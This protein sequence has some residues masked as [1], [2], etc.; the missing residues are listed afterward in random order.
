[1]FC[2]WGFRSHIEGILG[3]LLNSPAQECPRRRGK[4]ARA[5]YERTRSCN[6]LTYER[7]RESFRSLDSKSRNGHDSQGNLYRSERSQSS[8]RHNRASERRKSYTGGEFREAHGARR[9]KDSS[10]S[11]KRPR[12][13]SSLVATANE[14]S[15]R[16]EDCSRESDI[17]EGEIA[18]PADTSCDTVVFARNSFYKPEERKTYC[19]NCASSEH[20]GEVAS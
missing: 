2:L 7:E 3:P 11:R 19:F 17:E 9:D 13:S 20:R 8:P 1:M 4:F 16:S 18:Q 10:T 5:R 6:D 15:H 14:S 12:S